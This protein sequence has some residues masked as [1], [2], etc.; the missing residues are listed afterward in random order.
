MHALANAKPGQR[1]RNPGQIC[2]HIVLAKEVHGKY[3]T[4]KGQP[5]SLLD[6]LRGLPTTE[7]EAARVAYKF[8]KGRLLQ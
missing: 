2:K 1:V 3:A 4:E 8:E 5:S 6:M 7:K